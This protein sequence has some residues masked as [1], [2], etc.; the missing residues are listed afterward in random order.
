[1]SDAVVVIPTY[2]ERENIDRMVRRVLSLPEAV[3]L[4]VV[5]DGSPDGTGGIVRALQAEFPERLFLEVREGQRGLGGAYLHGFAWALARHYEYVFEMDADFSHDPG[6]LVRLR[7]AC[8]GGA[9]L[10]VGSRYV[11]GGDIRNWRWDRLALSYFA[12]LYVRGVL[13]LPVR[14]PTAGFKCYR[15]R[16][17]E[18]IDLSRIRFVGYAF[19]VEMK[20]ATHLQGFR[21]A[22][23]PIVFVDRAEGVSKMSLKI[24]REALGGVVQLRLRRW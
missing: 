12:S 11:R 21:I 16:V 23:V 3:D 20:Y 19:Q 4:L 8:E 13:W 5:D 17:L 24:F 6:D 10:A 15:R 22:E 14:D 7:R 1:M 9:D 18:R 2:N